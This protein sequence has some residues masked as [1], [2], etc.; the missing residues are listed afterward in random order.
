MPL[1]IYSSNAHSVIC[2]ILPVLCQWMN[3][4]QAYRGQKLI[5]VVRQKLIWVGW[6]VHSIKIVSIDNNL[7]FPLMQLTLAYSNLL[8]EPKQGKKTE[9]NPH[10]IMSFKA[11]EATG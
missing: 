11:I 4:A 9:Q 3:R 7:E 5:W 8:P 2:D 10:T 6:V 1:P